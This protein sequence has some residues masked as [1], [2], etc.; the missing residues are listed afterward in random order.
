MAVEGQ[1]DA[2][3]KACGRTS[4]R[5]R[6]ELHAGPLGRKA[7]SPLTGRLFC[8]RKCFVG[9]ICHSRQSTGCCLER[10]HSGKESH[11][12]LHKVTVSRPRSRVRRKCSPGQC[13]RPVLQAVAPERSSLGKAPRWGF[14]AGHG[15]PGRQGHCLTA[16]SSPG[17]LRT[18]LSWVRGG[19]RALHGSVHNCPIP[20]PDIVCKT[21]ARFDFA[22]CSHPQDEDTTPTWWDYRD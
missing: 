10:G 7:S 18:G 2:L 22:L 21:M 20:A 19:G 6:A 9:P 1:S 3:C 5:A 13:M 14:K 4:S 12:I 8:L 16:A 11:T 17:G 15:A